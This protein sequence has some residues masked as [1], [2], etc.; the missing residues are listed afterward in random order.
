MEVDRL[1]T[2]LH[3]VELDRTLAAWI[4]H[5]KKRARHLVWV[6]SIIHIY[7]WSMQRYSYL[8]CLWVHV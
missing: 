7:V 6:R 2:P 8:L 1:V 3:F 5:V 4:F